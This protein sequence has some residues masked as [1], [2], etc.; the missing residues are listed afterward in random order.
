MSSRARRFLVLLSLVLVAGSAFG[1]RRRAVRVPSPDCTYSLSFS[2]PDPVSDAGIA[3]SRVGVTPSNPAQCAGWAAFANVEWIVVDTVASEGASYVS[4]LPNTTSQPR[5]GQVRIGGSTL[6][7]TQVGMS[8]PPD[9][10]IIQNGR[11]NVDLANWGWPARFPNGNGSATWSSEDANG[12]MTSGSIRLRDDVASGPSY[13][14]M[15]C[16]TLEPGSYEYGL[17]VRSSSRSGMQPFLALIYFQGENCTGDYTHQGAPLITVR[18]ANVWERHFYTTFISQRTSI[19]VLIAGYARDPGLQ[20][21]W[22]D[23]VYMKPRPSF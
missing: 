15:Q 19:G 6:T 1:A 13:Q 11:F 10:N 22:I 12:S 4:V 7:I 9:T 20:E 21:A 23:D 14:Q 5:V 2:L 8:E 3:R 17:A 16:V 18:E